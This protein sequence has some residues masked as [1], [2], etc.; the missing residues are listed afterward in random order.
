MFTECLLPKLYSPLCGHNWKEL[1]ESWPNA[2][3]TTQ[4]PPH[5]GRLPSLPAPPPP[6]LPQSLSRIPGVGPCS[7]WQVEVVVVGGVVREG[8][9]FTPKH[10]GQPFHSPSQGCLG[11]QRPAAIYSA[12]SQ[13][14]TRL[15]L[16]VMSGYFRAM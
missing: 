3:H 14:S 16:E 12:W 7:L 11:H 1:T 10:M 6:P 4:P 15:I 2:G 9:N 5:Q 8:N 13:E